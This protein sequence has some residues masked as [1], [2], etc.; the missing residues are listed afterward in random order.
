LARRPNTSRT[1]GHDE[2]RIILEFDS[3][4]AARTYRHEHGTGGWIFRPENGGMTVLFPP[5]MA[6]TAIMTHPITKGRS[7][8]LMGLYC[9]AFL[10]SQ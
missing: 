10:G 4:Q 3:A 8:K 7:G 6:P 9:A 5:D 1:S 2:T